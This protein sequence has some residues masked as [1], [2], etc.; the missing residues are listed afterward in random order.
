[1]CIKVF[2]N[3]SFIYCKNFILYP[4]L[5]LEYF[6]CTKESILGLTSAYISSFAAFFFVQFD[7]CI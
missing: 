3:L 4:L 1:M 6:P 2:R 5:I 7:F